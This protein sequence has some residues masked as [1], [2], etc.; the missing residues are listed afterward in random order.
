MQQIDLFEHVAGAYGQ[1]AS[2]RLSNTELYRMVAGRACVAEEDLNKRVP[3]G[4]AGAERSI[5]KRA[6][7][8]H[9]QT[10]RRLGIVEKV[11]GERGVWELTQAGRN[12]LRK[13]HGEVA[14]LGFSTDLGVAILGNSTHVFG[15]WDEPIFLCLTSPPYPIQ[16]ARAYGGPSEAEYTDFITR[17]LEPIVRNLVPGGNVVVNVSNDVFQSGSPARSL[18]VEKLTIALCERLGLYLMDRLV[19]ENPNKPPGP[20]QWASRER[21][22]LNV[23]YEP[24]LW[25]CNAPHACIADNRRVLEPHSE[26]HAKLI[27][28]GGERRSRINSD[29]AYRIKEGAFG[30]PTVGR[31][32]RNVLRVS[33]TCP[34]QQAYKRAARSLG[35]Q[36]HGAPMPLALARKLVRFLSAVG[37]LVVDPCAGSMTTPLAAEL[38]DREWAAVDTVFD[39]VRGGAE[40]FRERQGFYLALDTI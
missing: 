28:N 31:I 30:N 12:K 17:I 14:V 3:I 26:K 21:M 25:F 5:V 35:L 29:G 4:Q 9:Q 32:P 18:Y 39:Y 27:A 13:I 33:G 10:L 40:R 23:G 34:S 6:I 38:E 11:A 2:G 37:Q 22:Q 36:A 15:R 8:W 1:P 19:W 16:R 24:V 7:R 20:Y